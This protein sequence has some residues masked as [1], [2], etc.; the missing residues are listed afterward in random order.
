MNA[1]F[2]LSPVSF[3]GTPP[4]LAYRATLRPHMTFDRQARSKLDCRRI[5]TGMFEGAQNAFR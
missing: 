4:A 3:H 2:W 1:S 5:W